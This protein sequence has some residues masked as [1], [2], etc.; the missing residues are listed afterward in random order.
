MDPAEEPELFIDPDHPLMV[1]LQA[2]L[3]KQ[4]VEQIDA[5]DVEIKEIEDS[6]KQLEKEKDEIGVRTYSMQQA[7]AKIHLGIQK[8]DE[9]FAKQSA[10]RAETEQKAKE[11]EAVTANTYA[12]VQEKLAALSKCQEEVNK[13]NQAQ[14]QVEAYREELKS[15]IKLRERA[16]IKA[17]EVAVATEKAKMEQDFLIDK[18]N[19][20]LKGLSERM[21]ILDEQIAAQQKDTSSAVSMLAEATA[22][23]EAISFQKKMC[24]H[25]WK[26]ALA[27]LARQNDAIT[28]IE[29]DIREKRALLTT[30]ENEFNGFKAR[31]RAEQEK[32][33]SLTRTLKKSEAEEMYLD[34]R[35]QENAESRDRVAIDLSKAQ[36]AL[37]SVEMDLVKVEKEHKS[38][39]NV[40]QKLQKDGDRY[41][42]EAVTIE[43]AMAIELDEQKTHERSAQF[44]K[45]SA[46]KL[47]ND[48][49]MKAV[50]ASKLENEIAQINFDKLNCE[51]HISRLK[52]MANQ[53]QD[54]LREKDSLIAKYEAEIRRNNDDIE[55]KQSEVDRLNK[56]LEALTAKTDDENL[57]P[58]EATIHNLSNEISEKEKECLQLQT[59]WLR[60]QSEYVSLQNQVNALGEAQQDAESKQAILQQKYLRLTDQHSTAK[61]EINVIQTT[62]T[63]L[64]HDMEKLNSLIDKNAK[65]KEMLSQD[66][67]TLNIS[68][69]E[70]IEKGNEE[71][72]NLEREVSSLT[73]E[74]QTMMITMLELEQEAMQWEKKAQLWKEMQDALDPSIGASETASFRK[75]LHVMKIKFDRLKRVEE[76]LFEEM[77][78]GIQKRGITLNK[79][80][81]S[82]K[83]TTKEVAAEN[84]EKVMTTLVKELKTIQAEIYQMDER[85]SQTELMNNDALGKI[86]M[87]R[88]AMTQL[89]QRIQLLKA[90]IQAAIMARDKTF[91][92][93]ALV[94]SVSKKNEGLDASGLENKKA[95]LEKDKAKVNIRTERLQRVLLETKARHPEI[96]D[97]V[98]NACSSNSAMLSQL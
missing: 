76:A 74:K 78:I 80:S 8:S 6:A 42:A 33:E 77:K 44:S 60:A 91:R 83:R 31:E 53:A 12:L 23:M 97:E 1:D 90:N 89:Q 36:K 48:I 72:R 84:V 55:R 9:A 59:F 96:A 17:G 16:A 14:R 47:V 40:A 29:Q 63:R 81:A 26:T 35:I 93:V 67:L 86:E 95:T 54:D 57:G 32:N 3:T 94:Q 49:E 25:E 61:K 88:D 34:K 50:E 87:T 92:E 4:L 21:S 69:R 2:Q 65:K 66:A 19:E 27:N 73:M 39:Q 37:E 5:L 85:I 52:V 46:K 28:K 68:V 64:R 70:Q 62:I 13:L 7:L 38:V 51:A 22:E 24:M 98:D 71:A 56:K 43:E 45:N 20:E 41:V 11:A 10:I 30:V 58:L 82:K 18:M 15:N 79:L 75:E